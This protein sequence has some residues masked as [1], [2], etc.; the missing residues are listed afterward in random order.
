IKAVAG[1]KVKVT[2]AWI[3]KEYTA[4]RPSLNNR[5]KTLVNDLDLRVYQKNNPSAIQLPWKLDVNNPNAAATKGDNNTDNVEQVEF[6]PNL[7]TDY[8]VE[9]K[10]KGNLVNPTK[11]SIVVNAKAN[12][13]CEEKLEENL[14]LYYL[15]ENR[16]YVKFPLNKQVDGYEFFI[17]D[18]TGKLVKKSTEISYQ[19]FL[20]KF[21][22]SPGN[23]VALVKSLG[24][25]ASVK[26][27]IN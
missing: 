19:I 10:H 13:F 6:I 8:I 24:K 27:S 18:Y 5:T 17:Y 16:L 3:D 15:D 9:V 21:N 23:Y 11:Y 20:K 1:S 26:F 22:L 25:S 4:Y 2:L 12:T 14:S 7:T